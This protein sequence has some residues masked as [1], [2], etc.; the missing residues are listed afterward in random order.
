MLLQARKQR[1][2]VVIYC[3]IFFVLHVSSQQGALGEVP[4]GVRLY[5]ALLR[6]GLEENETLGFR[7]KEAKQHS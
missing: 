7:Y 5:K 3:I 6:T 4:M 1:I 2:W